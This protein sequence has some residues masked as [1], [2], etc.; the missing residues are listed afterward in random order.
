[1]S[2]LWSTTER[3][4]R[5]S[6]YRTVW[7]TSYPVTLDQ[8]KDRIGIGHDDLSSDDELQSLIATATQLVEDTTSRALMTQSRQLDLDYFPEEIEIRCM[9]VTSASV[10]ITYV[11]GGATL[12]VTSTDYEVDV[13]SI[14]PRIRPDYGIVWPDTDETLRA[15]HVAF[16]AG[17]ASID[18]VPPLAKRAVLEAVDS[19]YRG[20]DLSA[21]Y[22]SLIGALGWGGYR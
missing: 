17:Y 8:V 13:V 12:T 15:V 1:M 4:P 7:P 2:L 14:P 6:M 11:S 9:P 5:T 22:Y 3:T 20:C 21:A 18:A 16:T 10:V 19:M